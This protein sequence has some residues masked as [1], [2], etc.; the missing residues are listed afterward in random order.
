MSVLVRYSTGP[1]TVEQYDE[2]LRRVLAVAG[3]WL[4]DGLEYHVC[5]GRGTNLHVI[6]IWYSR[7]QFDEFGHWLRPLLQG[8]GVQLDECEVSEIHNAMRQ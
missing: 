3:Q 6:D 2:A 4:P 7:E 5:F 8:V 1:M